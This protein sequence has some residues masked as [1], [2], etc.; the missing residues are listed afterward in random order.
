MRH[1]RVSILNSLP[2]IVFLNDGRPEAV[3]FE[4]VEDAEKALSRIETNKFIT[5]ARIIN[6]TV[7]S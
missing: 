4:T 7:K 3:I 2:T 6:A 1:V 5:D